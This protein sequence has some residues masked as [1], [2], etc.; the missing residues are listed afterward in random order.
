MGMPLFSIVM[1]SHQTAAW[2]G[3]AIDSVRAQTYPD[4]ELIIVDDASTDGSVAAIR[5]AAGPDLGGRIILTASTQRLGPAEA[6]NRAILAARGRY[7]AF[8]DSDDRWRPN[9]LERQLELLERTRAVLVYASYSLM[10]ESGKPLGQR[11]LAP[12]SVDYRS[13]LSCNVIGCLTACYDTQQ[14]GKVC[15]PEIARRQDHGLWLRILK[16]GRTALGQDQVLADYRVRRDSISRNKFA[17]AMWQ[18]RLYRD[19]EQLRLLSRAFVFLRYAVAGVTGTRFVS[20]S[21]TAQ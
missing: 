11:A 3:E 14:I 15:M 19:V 12:A 2:V 9:K 16:P 18:W 6:R 5:G 10:D 4:W 21:E 13:L 8:L 1:P 17:A 7:V 20:F